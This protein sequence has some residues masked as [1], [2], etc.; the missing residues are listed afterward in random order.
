MHLHTV[1]KVSDPFAIIIVP[2]FRQMWLVSEAR[3]CFYVTWQ[4]LSP[5][6]DWSANV[7]KGLR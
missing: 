5:E 6:R 1:R 2:R 3:V 4:T 7:P